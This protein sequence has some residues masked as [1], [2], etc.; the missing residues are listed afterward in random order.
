MLM[1]AVVPRDTVVTYKPP[2]GTRVNLSTTAHHVAVA[3]TGDVHLLKGD[4]VSEDDQSPTNS[5]RGRPK[6]PLVYNT[7]LP[8]PAGT[9][10]HQIAA[11][12]NHSTGSLS[13]LCHASSNGS[14]VHLARAAITRA[15]TLRSASDPLKTSISTSTALDRTEGQCEPHKSLS[16]TNSLCSDTYDSRPNSF[17]STAT[18]EVSLAIPLDFEEEEERGEVEPR[19]PH[20]Q[21]RVSVR[22]SNTQTYP[23]V[24]VAQQ[25][26]PL[27]IQ[28]GCPRPLGL[29]PSYLQ[30]RR[31]G[32]L[33]DHARRANYR[34]TKN[35][36]FDCE[37]RTETFETELTES[38]TDEREFV[39]LMGHYDRRPHVRLPLTP[40]DEYFPPGKEDQDFLPKFLCFALALVITGGIL[41]GLNL[42]V[43]RMNMNLF[44]A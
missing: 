25:Q 2:R 26:P 40:E 33:S 3:D 11:E 39:R 44:S 15:N 30:Q 18:E 5:L 7:P 6:S 13:S 43:S 24:M 29:S 1:A 17:F 21:P 37:T 4:V 34:G 35:V 14:M 9:T 32:L 8:S 12:L 36:S 27:R 38:E 19:P 22:H 28:H 16:R 20:P 10:N 42:I 31:Q 23:P 41:Y